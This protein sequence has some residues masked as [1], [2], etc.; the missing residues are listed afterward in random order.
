MAGLLAILAAT[1]IAAARHHARTVAI[2]R[3]KVPAPRYS[4]CT[5]VA[6][7]RSTADS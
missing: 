2:R 7:T 5:V 1:G 6:R 3:W 4:H